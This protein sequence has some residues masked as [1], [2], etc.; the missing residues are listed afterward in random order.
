[1]TL[2]GNAHVVRGDAASVPLVLALLEKEGIRAA[3]NPDVYVRE[4]AFFGVDEAREI[5]ER[6]VLKGS[7]GRRAFVLCAPGMTGEAQ[8]ALLKTL[9]EAPGDALFFLIVPAPNMLLSTVRSRAQVLA[10]EGGSSESSVDVQAFLSASPRARLDMLKPLLD[11][12]ED[13]RRDMG[14]VLAFLSA[15]ERMLAAAPRDK[16]LPG[17][18]AIYR[19]KA[20][21]SDKGALVKPLLEQLALLV[22]VLK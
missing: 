3:G 1:M 14:A 21:A 10:L 2:V 17:L 12:G 15:L 16:L 13:E 18:E 22:P 20:Y 6:A 9:E 5:R 4:Y 8:N 19:A 11:K 7:G